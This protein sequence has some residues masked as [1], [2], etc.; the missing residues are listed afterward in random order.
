MV[1]RVKREESSEEVERGSNP[2]LSQSERE[3][4]GKENNYLNRISMFLAKCEKSQRFKGFFLIR[5]SLLL[6]NIA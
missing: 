3:T 1:R 2:L 6:H 5:F 4:N